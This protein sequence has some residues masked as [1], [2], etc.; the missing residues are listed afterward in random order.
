[1]R[2]RA[3]V[4]VVGALVLGACGDEDGDP[5]G[6]A[7]V[8]EAE[9]TEDVGTAEG[10]SEADPVSTEEDVGSDDAEADAG[11]GDELQE[12]LDELDFGDGGARV[13]L[14]GATYEF[15]LGGNS[16]EI[17]GKTY[18]GICQ[19]LFGAI[20]GAGYDTRDGRVL[21]VEFDIP[22]VDWESYE[23]GRFETVTPRIKVEEVATETAWV[24]D[25]ALADTY[26][27]VAG[28]S[29]IDEWASDGT[30][31]SGTATFIEIEPYGEP[32]EGA[33]PLQGTFELA[34]AQD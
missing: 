4:L 27:Q 7:A 10:S 14:D 17:D 23:D 22:P 1:M 8:A 5:D 30:V 31:A 9:G 15:T 2:W 34:C 12:L 29:Q 13:V 24:A 19:Q 32:V 20:T 33:A 21:T 25:M 26:A 28:S 3:T 16:G 6:Q 18:L 11:D